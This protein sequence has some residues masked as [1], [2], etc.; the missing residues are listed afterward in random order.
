[1]LVIAARRPLLPPRDLLALPAGADEAERLEAA[2]RRVDGAGLQSGTVGDVEAVADA[3]GD[4]LEHEGR[5]IGDVGDD[6]FY[7]AELLYRRNEE[8][9]GWAVEA[10][11]NLHDGPALH[12]SLRLADTMPAMTI[13][14]AAATVCWLLQAAPAAPTSRAQPPSSSPLAIQASGA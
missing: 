10:G 6:E 2:Q 12:P 11:P 13:A 5:G 9:E 8:V 14:I 4:G 7:I 1:D 3:V